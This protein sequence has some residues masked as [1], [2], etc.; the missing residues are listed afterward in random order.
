MVTEITGYCTDVG[1]MVTRDGIRIRT[2][3]RRSSRT[4]STKRRCSRNSQTNSLTTPPSLLASV[5][6]PQVT[7]SPPLASHCQLL[8][9]ESAA[10]RYSAPPSVCCCSEA[11]RGDVTL[12]KTP[13]AAVMALLCRAW[14]ELLVKVVSCAS[15]IQVIVYAY[16]TL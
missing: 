3:G 2:S 5:G 16:T 13:A 9:S 11:G 10:H 6:R 1:K 14:S 15:L 7:D 8:L 4:Q 12:T